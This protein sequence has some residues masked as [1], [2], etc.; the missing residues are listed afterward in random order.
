MKQRSRGTTV[1]VQDGMT[2]RQRPHGQRFGEVL[3]AVRRERNL[4]QQALADRSDL[5]VDTVR[6]VESGTFSPSL[7][8]LSRLA[9]GLQISLST[10]FTRIDGDQ[11]N[12]LAEELW[13][14]LS[15]RSEAELKV[16]RRIL[17]AL[18]ERSGD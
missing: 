15:S 17:V 2:D 12:T 10:L 6:R 3:R 9:R 18:F 16:A 4:S 7:E 1:D 14:Y 11:D 13:D 5:A 8:T